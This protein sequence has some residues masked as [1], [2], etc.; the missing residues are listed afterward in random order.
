[1]RAAWTTHDAVEKEPQASSPPEASRSSNVLRSSLCRAELR[2]LEKVP[3]NCSITLLLPLGPAAARVSIRKLL[4]GLT[5][6]SAAREPPPNHHE[7]DCEHKSSMCDDVSKDLSCQRS[8]LHR[9]LSNTSVLHGCFSDI[10]NFCT[11]SVQINLNFTTDASRF[12]F[13]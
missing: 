13:S 2:Q 1:M 10:A 11:A 5:H 9:S 7:K 6:Q 3:H 8:N 4:M 12:S